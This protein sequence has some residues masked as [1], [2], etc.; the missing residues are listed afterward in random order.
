LI[1][2]AFR[3]R[4]HA[5]DPETCVLAWLALVRGRTD[6]PSAAAALKARLTRLRI[7][8]LS[9]WQRRIL[10]LLAFVAR[11]RRRGSV[12]AIS[13]NNPLSKKGMS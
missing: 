12:S 9:A 2:T 4:S 1:E 13:R 8:T 3:H 6:V 7:G 11:H 5:D 10:E